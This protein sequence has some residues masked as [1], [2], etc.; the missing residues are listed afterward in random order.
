MAAPVW[1][2]FMTYAVQE[3][4][5]PA[6]FENPPSWVDATKVSICRASGYLARS[7][8]QAVPLF[9]PKGKAPTASCPLHGGSYKA[10]E[11]DPRGPRLFLV[12]KDEAY[13]ARLESR[14]REESYSSPSEE[15]A[16]PPQQVTAP[17]TQAAI[18]KPSAPAPSRQEPKLSEVEQ[19]YRQLLKE[20]GLE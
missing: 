15:T 12:E 13:L 8:C 19:R 6:N 2:K 7:G 4:S 9:F 11:N 14:E 17:A 18:P 10:A 20:Y 1:K 3:M 5:T 16:T